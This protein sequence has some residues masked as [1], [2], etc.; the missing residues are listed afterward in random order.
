MPSNAEGKPIPVGDSTVAHRTTTLR[1]FNRSQSSSHHHFGE[2]SGPPSIKSITTGTYSQPIIV[3]TYSNMP[4]SSSTKGPVSV[5]TVPPTPNAST[6]RPSRDGIAISM[7]RYKGNEKA[8]VTTDIKLPPLD[9]FTFKSI[10]ENIKHD[11]GADLDRI[12]EIC[13][14]SRYSLSNQYEVHMTPQGSGA[15]FLGVPSTSSSTPNIPTEPTL[16][17]IAS[18][19]EH[20]STVRKKRRSATRRRSGAYGT[21]E[22]IISSSRSSDEDRSKKKP[23]AQIADEVRQHMTIGGRDESG[24]VNS[25][26]GQPS[27]EQQEHQQR[28]APKPAIFATAILDN[29]R[30]ELQGNVGSPRAPG[31]ILLSEP[32]EPRTSRSYLQTKTSTED[33]ALGESGTGRE[34]VNSWIKMV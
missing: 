27:S 32:A 2:G 13:A 21:L 1:Q 7:A 23:A 29:F 24:S 19:D 26:E 9:A 30:T 22:T 16:Q 5:S 34:G 17:A 6:W 28:H 4:T 15:G 14:G 18:D 8:R 10:M 20:T 12:A 33:T 25:A 31:R 3:R 11:V